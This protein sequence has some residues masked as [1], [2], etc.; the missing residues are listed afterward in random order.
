MHLPDKAK[1]NMGRDNPME[2]DRLLRLIQKVWDQWQVWFM[3][4]DRDA[5]H[6]FVKGLYVRR[7]N[8]SIETVLG[9]K[10]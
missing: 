5:E 1:E 7:W 9:D 2:Y 4:Q 6:P 10:K 3:D 8:D